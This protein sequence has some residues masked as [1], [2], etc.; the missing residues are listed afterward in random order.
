MS[1]VNARKS[2]FI[3]PLTCAAHFPGVSAGNVVQTKAVTS[4]VLPN[5]V[6]KILYIQI[7]TDP[8]FFIKEISRRRNV[9]R[10]T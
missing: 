5:K 8:Q 10:L 7:Q 3:C 2:I 6:A 9:R 1:R 4:A